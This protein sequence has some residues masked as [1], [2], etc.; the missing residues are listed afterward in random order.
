MPGVKTS[1]QVALAELVTVRGVDVNS[2]TAVAVNL[3]VLGL[4]GFNGIQ[5]PLN[6]AT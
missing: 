1:E 5:V 4:Q 6:E 3:I 2:S